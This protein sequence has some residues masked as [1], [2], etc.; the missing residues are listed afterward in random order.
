[1]SL[2][3]YT[4]NNLTLLIRDGQTAAA[5]KDIVA[6]V[7]TAYAWDFPIETA[8]DVGA[9]IGAW[10]LEAKRRN[11]R[12]WVAAIEVDPQNYDIL[13]Q[14]TKGI[15]NVMRFNARAGYEDGPYVIGRHLK[16]SGSTSVH[17]AG[18][19]FTANRLYELP[20]REWV[21]SPASITI[22]DIMNICGMV[23]FVDV[24]KLDCEGAEVEILN[25]ISEDALDRVQ[26][27]VGE[28]HTDP[29]RF[30]IATKNR[31]WKSGFVTIYR[32]HP[33]D[34]TLFYFHAWKP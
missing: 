21:H 26:H 13:E 11:P 12:A 24:L 30:A 10:T 9:H 6:E 5:E 15:R 19:E 20:D 7:Q 8:I 25:H 22:E 23:E 28:I 1:M 3:P 4:H 18:P 33:G 16:N 2:T 32:A 14:N 29:D 31:L 34:K 17:R 27:I